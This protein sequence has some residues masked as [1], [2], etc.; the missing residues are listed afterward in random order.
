M[1]DPRDDDYKI[2]T[3]AQ[4]REIYGDPLEGHSP[5]SLNPERVPSGLRHL[6]PLAELF[7]QAD[8]LL[9]ETLIERS[10]P[11]L[12]EALREQVASSEGDLDAW[13]AGPEA[14]SDSPSDEYVA[15]SAMRMAVDY[16]NG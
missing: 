10:P 13:L 6:I 2:T 5:L 16:L 7:G 8:D 3:G 11:D 9:R 12:L 1:T 4:L 15:F 14:D